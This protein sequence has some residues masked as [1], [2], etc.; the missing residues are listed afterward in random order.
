NAPC[1]WGVLE[2]ELE[3]KSLG[4]EQVLDEI[5]ET[6]YA[7][8][9]LGDWGFM[10]TDPQELNKEIAD[11]K[12]DLLG[13]FVPVAL[14]NEAAHE[15]GVQKALD[16]AELM[17]NAGYTDAFIVL[18]DDNGSVKERTE[19]AGRIT[20]E[21]SLSSE[22]MK[23]FA[24][25][26]EK[27]AQAVKDKFEMRTVFHHHCAGYI[28]TP[29]EIDALMNATDP[30]LLGLCF[31]TGHYRFGGGKDPVDVLEKYWDRIWHIHFKDFSPQVAEQSEKNNCDYF[32]SV[33]NGVFCELGK[34]DVDFAV[35]KKF[36]NNK[37]YNGWIVVEQD[38]LPGMGNPKQCA[39]NNRKYLQSIGL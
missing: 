24:R 8:T 34:G 3:G 15:D 22:Q 36:L 13:A 6:G 23:I 5:A 38:V 29:A 2:F 31:D 11:R 10:P 20:N 17:C 7:G 12:L 30:A 39:E 32:E 9:E 33:K 25:G 14:A 18:A 26:A 28:E 19:N 4:Y 21:Q 1:S 16:V 27:I 35:I 37:S